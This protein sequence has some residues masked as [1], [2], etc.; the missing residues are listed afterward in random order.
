MVCTHK[1]NLIQVIRT[2][3]MIDGQGI[4]HKMRTREIHEGLFGGRSDRK[5]RNI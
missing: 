1:I 4:C 3:S 5:I 2:S